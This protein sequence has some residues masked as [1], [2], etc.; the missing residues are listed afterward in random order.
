[1]PY[2]A[3]DARWQRSCGH[4][5]QPVRLHIRIIGD[6]GRLGWRKAVGYGRRSHA[7]TDMFRNKAVI[8]SRLRARILPAQKT[9]AKVG[10]SML[11]RTARLGMPVSQRVL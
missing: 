6:K 7:E 10:F 5:T 3:T 9:E 2:K 8:G 11:N 4:G 1:M